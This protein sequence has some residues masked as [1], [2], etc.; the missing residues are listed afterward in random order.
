MNDHEREILRLNIHL[1]ELIDRSTL[2]F[3]GPRDRKVAIY[4]EPVLLKPVASYC[5][6]SLKNDLFLLNCHGA[7]DLDVYELKARTIPDGY[8]KRYAQ[9]RYGL[10]DG[11]DP[12]AI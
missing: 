10:I 12:L 2:R 8:L 11:P 1:R 9:R 6:K 7:S 5:R 3:W 4:T